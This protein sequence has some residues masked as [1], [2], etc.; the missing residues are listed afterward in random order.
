MK[1]Y[2]LFIKTPGEKAAKF[3]ECLGSMYSEGPSSSLLDYTKE[4]VEKNKQT[5]ERFSKYQMKHTDCL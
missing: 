5:G 2:N 4:W 3:V 1:L